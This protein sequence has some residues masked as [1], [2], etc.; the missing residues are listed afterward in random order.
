M[1][2]FRAFIVSIISAVGAFIPVL[3]IMY[4]HYR[5]RRS[6]YIQ[7]KDRFGK[8]VESLKKS[9]AQYEGYIDVHRKR[10]N[11]K[12]S[13]DLVFDHAVQKRIVESGQ[14]CE[15]FLKYYHSLKDWRNSFIKK[16]IKREAD[17][18]YI[19]S[20]SFKRYLVGLLNDKFTEQYFISE[21]Q[22]EI[23]EKE[24]KLPAIFD[25]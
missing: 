8:E 20:Y 4:I 24:I 16:R 12:D 9:E 7:L 21:K 6:F 17:L 5:I 13:M 3:G 22:K 18:N 19:S 1:E 11:F 2:F 10:F 15:S 14:D 23:S 25:L